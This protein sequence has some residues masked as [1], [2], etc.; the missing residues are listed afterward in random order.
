MLQESQRADGSV[1]EK[2]FHVSDFDNLPL[3]SI[4]IPS[5]NSERT[6]AECLVSIISQS[7]RPIEIIV[8]DCFSTDSTRSIAKGLGAFVI[9]HDGERSMA[10]NLGA[11]LA[12]GKYLYFVD[13]DH[14]LGPDVIA[15]CV[16]TIEGFEAV[17]INDQDLPGN[18]KTS[19]LVA[20][21]RRILS[22][23]PLNVAP[24][25]VRKATFDRLGG[26]D[27][28]LYAGEDLDLYRRFLL[29]NFKMAYSEATEWHLGSPF[30]LKGLLNR[31]MYYS[32]NY[33]RYASK[34]PLISLKRMNPLRVVTAWKKSDARR[35]DLL[36]VV[37]LGFLS[38]AFLII[39]VLLNC[40]AREGTRKEAPDS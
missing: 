5:R 8:V 20:S 19:R 1:R 13:A 34:N 9:S 26:F 36:P 28:D 7:Y 30:D 14:K 35:S 21:R 29:N 37:L 24:R 10:K 32:S 3:V 27:S 12:K 40:N 17:L 15:A 25:F 11:N 4:I 23:D 38:N 33:L 16:R 6:I 2:E 39:G 31:S 18:S 22:Y